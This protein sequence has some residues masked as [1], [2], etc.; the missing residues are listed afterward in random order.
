MPRLDG[1]FQILEKIGPNAYKVDI[2]GEYGV[3]AS[4]NVA[5]LSPYYEDEEELPS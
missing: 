3:S 5:D 1:P 4:F 2:S